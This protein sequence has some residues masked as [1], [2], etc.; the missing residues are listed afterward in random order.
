MSFSRCG[1]P[2]VGN[3]LSPPAAS[4]GF[5]CVKVVVPTFGCSVCGPANHPEPTWDGTLLQI[6]G[7][8]CEYSAPATCKSVTLPCS[9]DRVPFYGAAID[10]GV[11]NAPH[12]L[13]TQVSIGIYCVS[14]AHDC[15]DFNAFLLWSG[16]KSD[17]IVS[18]IGTYSRTGGQS[19]IP[20]SITVEACP[21]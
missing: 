16:A 13:A 7:C 20:A 12:S 17:G 10:V 1:C 19:A 9:V 11:C 2:G 6:P 8:D 5:S 3:C 14:F 4:C 18:P 21:P 15:T